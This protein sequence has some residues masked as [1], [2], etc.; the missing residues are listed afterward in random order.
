MYAHKSTRLHICTTCNSQLNSRLLCT[1]LLNLL[2]RPSTF[3]SPTNICVRVHLACCFQSQLRIEFHCV[4]A[5]LVRLQ[6]AELVP[7]VFVVL[8]CMFARLFVNIPVP[9]ATNLFHHLHMCARECLFLSLWQACMPSVC[10]HVWWV[11]GAF[12]TEV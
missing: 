10:R 3:H 6:H 2:H 5:R 9:V 7:E 12:V 4:V 11:H 8:A 1:A